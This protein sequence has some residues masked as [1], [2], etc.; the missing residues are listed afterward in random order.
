[1]PTNHFLLPTTAIT[2]ATIPSL[3]ASIPSLPL[4]SSSLTPSTLDS[5]KFN[6]LPRARR[7]DPR[8]FFNSASSVLLAGRK[9]PTFD[10]TAS[11]C[12]DRIS[13]SADCL[14]GIT[15]LSYLEG[16][17]LLLN[18]PL[19][20]E[21]A[22]VERRLGEEGGGKRE[23]EERRVEEREMRNILVIYEFVEELQCLANLLSI[24]A[25]HHFAELVVEPDGECND[26]DFK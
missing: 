4:L 14:A 13:Q 18:L 21:G 9:V 19:L 7:C 25:P 17:D 11:S 26:L 1:M 6:S 3:P 12:S 8:V 24:V 23:G 20:V 22:R 16:G 15:T 10:V 5:R 2:T